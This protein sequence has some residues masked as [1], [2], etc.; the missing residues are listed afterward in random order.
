[1]DGTL[2][3]TS[4]E[5]AD[6]YHRHADTVYKV[7]YIM[8]HH[9]ADAEDAVQSTFIQLMNSNVRFRD[10][11]HEKAWLIVVAKNQCKNMLKHWW[12]RLK[13]TFEDADQRQLA[14]EDI[15]DEIIGQVRALPKKYRL[16]T[17]LFYYEGYRTKEIAELLRVKES[18]I[19][20][21]LHTTRQL[22]KIQMGGEDRD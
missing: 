19:R 10:Y 1:M 11:E 2:Q 16:P 8:L 22:L 17:L 20:S 4:E 13:T 3:R 7:C 15:H 14:S 5:I 6:L 12:R 21:Q 18:T 9:T